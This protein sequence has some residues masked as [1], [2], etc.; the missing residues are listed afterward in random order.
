MKSS[1]VKVEHTFGWHLQNSTTAV[2]SH[3]APLLVSDLHGHTISV[4]QW[5]LQQSQA[6]ILGFVPDIAS[7]TVSSF[8]AL[9]GFVQDCIFREAS[10]V[11]LGWSRSIFSKGLL[12]VQA[13]KNWTDHQKMWLAIIRGSAVVPSFI[14]IRLFLCTFSHGTGK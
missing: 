13:T 7:L 9:L 3:F 1:S 14:E 4:F 10:D 12:K 8:S 11:R 6:S 5:K 2:G